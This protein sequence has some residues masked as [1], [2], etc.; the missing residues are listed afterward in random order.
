MSKTVYKTNNYEE[1]LHIQN[2]LKENGIK[3]DVKLDG[4][5]SFLHNILHLFLY[6][7]MTSGIRR[8]NEVSCI[9]VD[10]TDYQK[11]C[12]VLHDFTMKVS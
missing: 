8:E 2:K 3:F 6:R 4:S 1:L 5:G 11:A 7:T 12:D 9:L 10:E